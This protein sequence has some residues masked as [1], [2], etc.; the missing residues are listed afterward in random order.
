MNRFEAGKSSSICG[1]SA[2]TLSTSIVLG[3]LAILLLITVKDIYLLGPP[4]TILI[5]SLLL[6]AYLFLFSAVLQTKY[7]FI[8]RLY[9]SIRLVCAAGLATFGAF[10]A[11]TAVFK[12]CP[13]G[14]S[15]G[16]C[17]F[18]SYIHLGLGILMSVMGV[19]GLLLGL[20]LRRTFETI[21]AESR[22]TRKKELLYNTYGTM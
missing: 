1:L 3:D 18:S 20:L 4:T 12:D 17:L 11:V 13:A 10:N 8:L 19:F 6:I 14:P 9:S 15:A 5:A 7:N 16:A 21:I 22:A 2:K